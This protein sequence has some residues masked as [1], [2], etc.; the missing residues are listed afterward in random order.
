MLH[1]LSSIKRNSLLYIRFVAFNKDLISKNRLKQ[2]QQLHSKK[3]RQKYSLFTVEGS[4][5]VDELLNSKYTVEH[6]VCSDEQLHARFS[7]KHETVSLISEKELKKISKHTTPQGVVAI[8]RMKPAEEP[9]EKW[10]LALFQL[11][12]PGN[13]GTIIRIADW[14][15]IKNIYCT[16][17]TVDKYNHKCIQASMGSFVRVNVHYCSLKNK[18]KGRNVFAAVLNGQNIR[19]LPEQEGGFIL[20]GNEANG[21]DLQFLDAIEHTPVSIPAISETESLNAA[22]ATAVICE[23]LLF[24]A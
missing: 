22:V 6:I 9:K 15:G 10:S 13:L 5:S 17:D 20:I 18:I 7:T 4:K 1:E 3:F 23:R 14:Y 8:V 19:K 21:I 2:Y 12:D 24:P 11:N 16:E